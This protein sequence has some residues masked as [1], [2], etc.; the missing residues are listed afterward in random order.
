MGEAS[1][2]RN[3]RLEWQIK[4]PVDNNGQWMSERASESEGGE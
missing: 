1:F 4:S 2:G 3:E